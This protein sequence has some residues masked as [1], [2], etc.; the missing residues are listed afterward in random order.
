[1]TQ[2]YP[3]ADRYMTGRQV[4]SVGPLRI[5]DESFV[6]V[7][8]PGAGLPADQM[9]AVAAMVSLSGTAMLRCG[10]TPL[11]LEQLVEA[12]DHAKRVNLPA[13][14]MVNS[15]SPFDSACDALDMVEL[16][17]ASLRDTSWSDVVRSSM[18]PILLRRDAATT[19]D[20]WLAA[21]NALSAHG[22]DVVLVS[23]STVEGW[24]EAALDRTVLPILVEAMSSTNEPSAVV[25]EARVHGAHGAVVELAP[26]GANSMN[27]DGLDDTGWADLL[28]ALEVLRTRGAI[29]RVDREIVRLLGERQRLSLEIGRAKAVRGLPVFAPDR[30]REL[31][32][33]LR[34]L[35]PSHGLRADHLEAIFQ[36][37]L[38][39]SRSAQERRRASDP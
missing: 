22:R 4:V 21:G 30:E 13:V 11:R 25:L 39:E 1:M 10:S 35:G 33:G 2:P 14:G 16:D 20:D 36:V 37:I 24:L 32:D 18:R 38:A 29:D 27:A 31:M 8:G 28:F 5:G 17:V 23:D 7:A 19:I 6:V 26:G 3:R 12:S 34:A 9:G 15:S